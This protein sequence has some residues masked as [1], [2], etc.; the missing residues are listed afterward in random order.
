MLVVVSIGTIAAGYI[1]SK[2]VFIDIYAFSYLHRVFEILFIGILVSHVVYT[3]R[4]F[5]L[6]LRETINKIGP[7]KR[8]SIYLLRLAQRIS[9]WFIVIAAL[10]MILTG[11]NGYAFIAQAIEDVIPFAP[12]RVFDVLLVAAIIVHV[13]IGIRFAFMRRRVNTKVARRITIGL[14]LML[15]VLTI[16]LNLPDSESAPIGRDA[17]IAPGYIRVDGERVAFQNEV[18]QTV[19]PDLFRPGSFSVF[20]VLVHLDGLGRLDLE[21]HFNASLNTHVIDSLNGEPYWW[22]TLRYSGG[23]LEENVYRMDHYMWKPGTWLNLNSLDDSEQLNEIYLTYAEEVQRLEDN[24]GVTILPYVELNTPEG[25]LTFDNIVVTPSNLR[26][27]TF[28]NGVITAIDVIM[29]LG[30][31]GLISYELQW[32]D[33]VGTAAVV[34]SY[35]VEAINNFTSQ[36]TCGFVYE[37]G[38]WEFYGFNGNHIHL[39]S[40]V[41]LLN[42]PEYMIWSWICV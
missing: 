33:S 37:T 18:V 39:P 20:D 11:L 24:N 42:S 31:L 34:R 9:S 19:R 14:T 36:G 4:H 41:R 8:N 12:H 22:Y 16:P 13:V 17:Y 10:G 7:E 1:V 27:D 40:D 15:L 6:N 23:W 3:L 38:S 35:W 29:A 5:K 2:R 21:Y 30:D 32:Y 26:N 28:Q 25:R